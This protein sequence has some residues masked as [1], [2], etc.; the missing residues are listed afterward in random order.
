MTKVDK[1]IAAIEALKKSIH[2]H[3]GKEWVSRPEIEQAMDLLD[4][5]LEE[6]DCV[7]IKLKSKSA[8][9]NLT[10]AV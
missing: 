5:V 3:H 1:A 4:E 7:G 2:H 6:M 8:Q 9:E 10:N